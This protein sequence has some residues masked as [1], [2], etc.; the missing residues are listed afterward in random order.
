MPNVAQSRSAPI[1]I[2]FSDTE[3]V[4]LANAAEVLSVS[5]SEFIRNASMKRARTVLDSPLAGVRGETQEES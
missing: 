2:R 4:L 3:R 1:S 5:P